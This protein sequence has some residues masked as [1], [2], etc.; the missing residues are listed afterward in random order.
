MAFKRREGLAGGPITRYADQKLSCCPF[1]GSKEPHWLMDAYIA[2]F[3]MIAAKCVNGYKFQCEKCEGIFEIQGKTDFCFQ[4]EK[5]V[6][7]KLLSVGKGHMNADKIN[8][9]LTIA[10][11]KEL[12]SGKKVDTPSNAPQ[13][14]DNVEEKPTEIII[15]KP[16]YCTKC[17]A[18]LVEGAN[19]CVS[20]GSKINN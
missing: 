8:K 20:C 2:N 4:W 19:F 1:C 18:K 9:P 16:K 7:I 3:S 11:L 15:E 12:C 10:E 13:T 5:F 14:T 17:G 6:S